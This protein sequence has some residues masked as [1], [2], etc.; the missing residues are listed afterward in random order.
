MVVLVCGSR[1]WK[2]ADAIRVEL[3]KLPPD[4]LVIHGDA[5]GADKI[6]GE[7][8][9]ALGLKVKAVPAKWKELGKSSGVL[10]NQHMLDMCPDLVIGF[11]VDV[12]PTSGTMDML[13]RARAKGVN[14]KVVFS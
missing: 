14:T 9:L 10:R 6:A 1:E 11:C 12:T 8:A 5:R 3:V 4:T 7:V 2:D 13:K